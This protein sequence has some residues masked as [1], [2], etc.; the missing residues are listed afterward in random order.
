MVV[1]AANADNNLSLLKLV[2]IMA[3]RVLFFCVALFLPAWSFDY[4]QAWL[5]LA[6]FFMPEALLVAYLYRNDRPLLARRLKAGSAAE[7]RFRQKIIMLLAIVFW[8]SIILTTGFDHRFHWSHVPAWLVCLA[9]VAN[10]AGFYLTYRVFRENSFAAATVR[11]DDG[12]KVI[13][14]GPYA[15]VRHPMYSAAVLMN[16]CLPVALGSW[17]GVPFSALNVCLIVVRLLDE[18]KMLRQDLPGYSEYC[19]KVRYRL[20]PQVW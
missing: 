9:D 11:V 20:I 17:W 2:W 6:A 14:T 5:F 7:T 1:M 16:L 13:A 18:E 15:V 3:R 10:L 4:W 19:G 12:Q 8:G